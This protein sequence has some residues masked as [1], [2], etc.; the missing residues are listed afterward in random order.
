MIDRS[1]VEKI[2]ELAALKTI[3]ING[4]TYSSR[5]LELVK[6]DYEPAPEPLLIGTLTGLVDYLQNNHDNA[7]Q[8]MLHVLSE[9]VVRL[10]GEYEPQFG[11]RKHYLTATYG[12]KGFKFGQY[13]DQESFIIQLQAMFADAGDR[14]DVMKDAGKVAGESRLNQS[15]DGIT[16]QVTVKESIGRMVDKPLMNPVQLAPYRT[17]PEIDQIV[18]PFVF[19]MKKTD[20]GIAFALFECDGDKWKLDAIHAIRNYLKEKLGDKASIIA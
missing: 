17:F 20:M 2:E 4:E 18:S 15:D 11:R 7:K 13:H 3:E 9:D 16:Q 12:M 19:R 8:Y 14:A 1:F 6:P 10:Y 5:V